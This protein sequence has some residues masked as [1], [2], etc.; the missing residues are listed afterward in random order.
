[1][2]KVDRWARLTVRLPAETYRRLETL[3]GEIPGTTPN[4]LIRLAVEQL[5][6]R[7]E[8]MAHALKTARSGQPGNA[9]DLLVAL[10]Q[11]ARLPT[12]LEPDEDGGAESGDP[13]ATLARIQ[14]VQ[15][16]Q[17]ER[18]RDVLEQRQGRALRHALE[19]AEALQQEQVRRVQEAVT[20]PPENLRGALEWVQ[21]L[22]SEQERWLGD[23]LAQPHAAS[24]QRALE[25]IHALQ[26]VQGRH[27]RKAL[28]QLQAL[29]RGAGEAA[30]G[31]SVVVATAAE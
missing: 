26:E 19:R 4:A 24:L 25:R 8:V 31:D 27:V 21:A 22:Q 18:V 23:L 2:P 20:A 17:S 29:Q 3:A 11:P 6:P 12:S 7:L 10:T 5:T 9:L 14:A 1:M 13:Q 28:E 15:Q 30:P 16:E